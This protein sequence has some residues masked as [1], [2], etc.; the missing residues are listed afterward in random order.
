MYPEGSLSCLQEPAAGPFAQPDESS[1]YPHP[2]TIKI[3][4]IIILPSTIVYPNNG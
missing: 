2:Y 3:N 4:L 1:P